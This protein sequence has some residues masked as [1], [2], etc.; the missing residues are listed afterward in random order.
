M[1]PAA[2]LA[3]AA[4]AILRERGER[5]SLRRVSAILEGNETSLRRYVVGANSPTTGKLL[6]WLARWE[7]A[8]Y[9]PLTV[10][11]ATGRCDVA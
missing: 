7:R 9:P 6:S 10:T 8:G 11:L 2:T 1:N 3:D 5:H 4:A